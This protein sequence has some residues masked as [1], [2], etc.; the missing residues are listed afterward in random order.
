MGGS[1]ARQRAKLG[2]GNIPHHGHHAQ[3]MHGGL[4]RGSKLSVLLSFWEFESS[5]GQELKLF[6]AAN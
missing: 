6:Q 5:L 1:T 2:S 4:A 3:F